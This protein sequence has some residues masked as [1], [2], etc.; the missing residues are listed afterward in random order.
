V[1]SYKKFTI[2]PSFEIIP[3]ATLGI[4]FPGRGGLN[5]NDYKPSKQSPINSQTFGGFVPLDRI[6]NND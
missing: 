5:T 4:S 6:V 2:S 1:K 3:L